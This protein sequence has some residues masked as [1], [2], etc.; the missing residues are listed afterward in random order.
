MLYI[1]II[2]LLLALIYHY[3]YQGHKKGRK[4]I[5]ITCAVIFI[6]VAGLRYRLGTDTIAYE[7]KYPFF[8][9]LF[10]YFSFDFSQTRYGP[11]FILFAAIPKTISN[12]FVLLQLFHA[13]FV[14]SVVFYFFYTNTHH[15]FFAVLLYGL[16]SYFPFTFEVLRESCAVCMLLIGW[17]FFLKSKWIKYYVCA[18]IAIL[19]HPS[20]A[21]MLIL[22]L[23]YIQ[24]IRSIF[25]IGKY[26]WISLGLVYIIVMFLSIK[27]FDLIRL[28]EIAD[29]DNYANSYENSKYATGSSMNIVGIVSWCTRVILYPLLAII[30]IKRQHRIK[31]SDTI[32]DEKLSKLEYMTCWF[33]YIAIMTLYI[34][35]F[36]RFN[37]Y[38]YPFAIVAISDAVFSKIKISNSTYRLRFTFWIAVL[39][40]FFLT[41]F[42]GLFNN[43]SGSGIPYIRRYYPYSSVI[44]PH[45]DKQRENLFS[46]HGR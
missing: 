10:E 20:G 35:L 13:A 7:N 43:D 21:V 36:Y 41:N 25:K 9:D 2:I 28:I 23:G 29:V 24:P 42:Y 40:P 17:K 11:G 30:I 8:P 34:K 3:D 5:Y 44:N 31:T 4:E 6:L 16:I 22:P 18:I 14:T 46:F 38:F 15:P 19:F 45:K 26:F 37:N 27:F 32:N 33:V 12:E 1:S 39:T